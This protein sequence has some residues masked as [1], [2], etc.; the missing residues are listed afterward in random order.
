VGDDRFY[1]ILRTWAD[2]RRYGNGS[3]EDFMALSETISGKGLMEL[4]DAW[5]FKAGKPE[6]FGSNMLTAASSS[7]TLPL[8]KSWAAIRATQMHHRPL[9]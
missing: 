3:I 9:R 1:E 4:F 6:V 2:T 7:S 5:L 8:P